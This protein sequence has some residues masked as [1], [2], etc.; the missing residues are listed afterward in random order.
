MWK[1]CRVCKKYKENYYV[2]NRSKDQLD[3][4]C[5][6][7]VTIQGKIDTLKRRKAKMDSRILLEGE[8]YKTCSISNNYE[9][10]NLGNVFSLVKCNPISPYFSPK[11]YL[12][13]K[14]C[15]GDGTNFCTGV[16]RMIALEFIPNPLNLP[17]VNHLDGDK[18]NNKVSNLEWA[19]TKQN[20]RHAIDTGLRSNTINLKNNSMFSDKDILD[21]RQMFLDGFGNQE[22]S[23]KYKCNHSTISKIRTG[24]HYPLIVSK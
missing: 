10:S 1:I 21:I 13:V 17:E 5:K 24:V 18:T 3:S 7:C 2:N 6:D 12:I 16:H 8:V 11:G 23:S 19:T 14:I 15:K 9:I 4:V 22:I 20:I